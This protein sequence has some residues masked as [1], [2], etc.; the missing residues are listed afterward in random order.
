MNNPDSMHDMKI[1]PAELGLQCEPFSDI[2]DAQFFYAE[3][4][5][6]QR[7]DLLTHLAQFSDSLL[8]VLG[9]EGSGKTTLLQ[10]FRAHAGDNWRLCILD[11][12]GIHDRAGLLSALL[13]AF[14]LDARVQGEEQAERLMQHCAALREVTELPV[15]VI[16]N[17]HCLS[18]ELLRGLVV[19][20]G[21][22]QRT[23]QQL[24]ILLLGEP[25]LEQVLTNAGLAP[26]LV[27][28]IQILQM[29]RFNE[30]QAAAYLMYRLTV[31]GYSGVSPF[32][33]T[34]VRAMA[35]H[36][37]GLPGPMNALAREAL[38][39]RH[40]REKIIAAHLANDTGK[41]IRRLLVAGIAG[42]A[43]L[44]ALFWLR[45]QDVPELSEVPELE[46]VEAIPGQVRRP[47]ALPGKE[48]TPQDPPAASPETSA[49]L[50]RKGPPMPQVT[51]MAKPKV[52]EPVPEEPTTPLQVPLAQSPVEMA[53]KDKPP[54]ESAPAA[55]DAQPAATEP[56]PADAEI[57]A[58]SGV[59][60][61]VSA[62]VTPAP[63]PD[64]PVKLPAEPGEAP[65]AAVQPAK[66]ASG[67]ASPW[68][69]EDW[70]RSQPAGHYTL[71]LL[72]SRNEDSLLAFIRTHGLKGEVAYFKRTHKGGDWYTLVYGSFSDR[73][74]A[75]AAL[76]R[77]PA[78]VQAA[79]PWP[80][81]LGS[82]QAQIPAP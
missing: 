1:D 72:G 73:A 80:R 79:K 38:R 70:I 75:T 48:V 76:G 56:A 59:S 4:A 77:L 2:P 33:A 17:A 58:A 69:R 51:P 34:D 35:K 36:S 57:P 16:D 60:A 63:T 81:T 3:P 37:A 32:T 40:G 47:L 24:R 28:Y 68:F 46:V 65:A 67:T 42:L 44:V 43:I 71:Q 53:K 21:D 20:G 14:G 29:P 25:S 52:P 45:E 15:L 78:K 82:V 26:G 6:M 22:P 11:G 7:L 13:E 8:V 18:A 31:A 50:V 61:G 41:G 5:F 62:T 49:P 74:A 23:V 10:Q 12:A 39:E 55:D 64:K 54:L 30:V 27:P 66:P 9:E 19:L